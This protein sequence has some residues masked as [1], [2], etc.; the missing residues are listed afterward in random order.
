MK[1]CSYAVIVFLVLACCGC[2]S[3]SSPG[4][5]KNTSQFA[6]EVRASQSYY[7]ALV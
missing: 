4:F 6:G 3:P 7:D 5:E 2:I 1:I